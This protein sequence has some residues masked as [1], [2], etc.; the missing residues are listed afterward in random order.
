MGEDGKR[1]EVTGPEKKERRKD[2]WSTREGEERRVGH[3]PGMRRKNRK[4]V[5]RSPRMAERHFYSGLA[6]YKHKRYYVQRERVIRKGK[7]RKW[8][9]KDNFNF[10]GTKAHPWFLSE[11]EG[12]SEEE[13]EVEFERRED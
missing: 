13:R 2:L 5:F 3:V 1:R 7:K 9:N 8:K 4:W 6:G 11:R 12:G 10:Q